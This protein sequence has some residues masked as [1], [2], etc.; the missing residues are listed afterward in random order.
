[1]FLSP[2]SKIQ[3]KAFTLIELL[4]VIA[5][6][7]TL[8]GLLLPAI[9][10]V[11]EAVSRLKCANN[12]KQIGLAIQNYHDVFNSFPP[13]G[14]GLVN[15]IPISPIHGWGLY[16]LPQLEQE[17]LF[18][19]YDW[20]R[21]WYNTALNTSGFSNQQVV[22]NKIPTFQCPSTPRG[23]TLTTYSIKAYLP[24]IINASSGPSDYSPFVDIQMNLITW[25]LQ[26]NLITAGTFNNTNRFGVLQDS[27]PHRIGELIDG[28]SNTVMVGEDAGRPDVYQLGK[29]TSGVNACAGW[30]DR[31]NVIALNGIRLD[32]TS[33]KGFAWNGPVC[34]NAVNG[35]EIYAFHTGGANS[36]FADARVVF[37]TTKLNIVTLCQL[38]SF[39][40]GQ[41][42]GDY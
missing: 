38:I 24:G 3:H 27:K 19:Q 14:G 20:N 10:K 31:E 22:Q 26:N 30:G 17:N 4:V 29:K 33:G 32:P 28:S 40:D 13:G 18:K 15:P 35:N 39:N 34:V 1:M 12:L 41:V 6:I 42:V 36:L 37:L 2:R 5:I 8:I 25:L 7:A 23:E 21:N 11:R 16:I 9:Q